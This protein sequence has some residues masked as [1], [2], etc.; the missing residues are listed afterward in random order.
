[1]IFGVV[2]VEGLGYRV[3]AVVFYLYRYIVFIVCVIGR[4]N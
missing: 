1:M 4:E 2:K 3:F